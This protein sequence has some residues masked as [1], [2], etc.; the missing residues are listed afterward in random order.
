M[1]AMPEATDSPL[2]EATYVTNTEVVLDPVKPATGKN[3]W[4]A[5]AVAPRAL[6][7]GYGTVV[8]AE[9]IDPEFRQYAADLGFESD[10]VIPAGVNPEALSILDGQNDP[11]FQAAIGGGKLVESYAAHAAL[12]Q[13]VE[14]NGGT[15]FI[16]QPD[17]AVQA[18]DKGRY[19]SLMEGIVEAPDGELA[20]G[21]EAITDAVVDRLKRD[22]KA[23]VRHTASGAGFGN[24]GFDLGQTPDLTRDQIRETIEGE[25]PELWTDAEALVEEYLILIH[26]LAVGFDRRG[27]TH[28]NLQITHGGKYWGAWSPIPEDIWDPT[29]LRHIGEKGAATL[30]RLTGYNGRGSNDIALT[31]DGLIGLENNARDTAMR[32]P[33]AI[34][35]RLF[36]TPWDQWRT[37]G[38]TIKTIDNLV[39]KS[40]MSFTEIRATLGK[41]GL[42]AS[43]KS[44]HGIIITIPPHGN[45]AGIQA[46]ENGY[47]RT[48]GL[49][50]EALKLIGDE[51]ANRYDNAYQPK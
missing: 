51:A 32:H 36:N 14:A 8:L 6:W 23:Y 12:G 35:T 1:S 10:V 28:D 20:K 19:A 18:N 44:P 11:A 25:H 16:D 43:T 34:A 31:P 3:A 45:V 49:F 30:R 5:L 15:Y 24:R 33:I 17:S 27:F 39:L 26:A 29:E 48:E 41:A 47:R 22:G 38:H 42:L 50:Q 4:K 7:F 46:Q 40:P 21:I 2:S 9:P 13:I 37:V